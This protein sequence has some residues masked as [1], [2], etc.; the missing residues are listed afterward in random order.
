MP[1]ETTATQQQ[2]FAGQHAL[3]IGASIAGLLAARVLSD[4]FERVT[5]VERDHLP[6]TAQARKGVPQGRHSHVFLSKGEEIVNDLFPDI[7][8]ALEADG[9]Q[10]IDAI[11]D[12]HW[13]HFGVWKLQFAGSM[14]VYAQSRPL[15]EHHVR[16]LVLARPNIRLLDTCEVLGLIG[17]ARKPSGIV[18]VRLRQQNREGYLETNLVVDASGRGSQ[19][20]RWLAELGYPQVEETLVNIG[21][22]YASRIYRRPDVVFDWKV[23]GVYPWPSGAKR[24]GIIF[25]IEGN[26]WFVSLSGYAHDYPPADEAGFLA[27]A[28]DLAR[29]D[30]YEAIKDA[31]PLSPI[32]VHKIPTDR[33]RHYERSRL[34]DG[35]IVLGD[36][37]CSLNP[38]Y[39]QGMTVATLGAQTLRDCL[40]QQVRSGTM[41]GFPPRFQK[42][43]ARMLGVPWQFT[44]SED[45]RYPEAEGKRSFGLGMLQRYVK[46]VGHLTAVD[47]FATQTFYEVLHMQKLPTA[48]FHPRILLSALFLR[49]SA[50]IAAK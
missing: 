16:R 3:V 12:F 31:E 29:P 44:V 48:L 30:L 33:Q 41:A 27:Y 5:I 7:F 38:I 6:E 36:A 23:L 46:R 8:P 25:P 9:A 24:L 35:L 22:G 21:V 4:Y 40:R 26:A 13:F 14:R 47:P 50:D 19:T 18:G 28:R 34:P 20:P 32:A 43:L 37:A 2:H 42:A 11:N 1:L 45:L 49:Q 39:A 15:L 17:E 10:L